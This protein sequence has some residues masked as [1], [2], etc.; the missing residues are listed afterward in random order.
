VQAT[1]NKTD[2]V[3]DCWFQLQAGEGG[4]A[5]C[6]RCRTEISRVEVECPPGLL[7][8]PGCEPPD[9]VRVLFVGVAP[10]KTGRHFYTDPADN[11]R[12]GLF[13]ILRELDRPC[14]DVP[15]FLA[16]GFFLVH[17]A[18]CAI[19]GTTKPNLRVSRCC[20]A[21]HLRREIE[22]LMPD[23]ICFLSKNIAFP[24]ST[25][26]LPRWVGT[27][28]G[29][30]RRGCHGCRRH[31]ANPRDLDYL[32]RTGSPQAACPGPREGA[33]RSPRSPNVELM[34]AEQAVPPDA[35][36]RSLRSLGAPQ[37]NGRVDMRSTV[38]RDLTLPDRESCSGCLFLAA[39]V[40]GA[41][42]LGRGGAYNSDG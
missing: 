3:R 29:T 17:T 24:V 8:P 4:V 28:T 18:K 36:P 30:V 19:R 5:G 13:D 26:L 20:G 31:E 21:T 10:P 15:D 6:T 40:K 32:A 27:Q 23:G 9:A 1:S 14:R 42:T 2:T 16:R 25:D 22:C 37:V 35:P 7:Y 34:D 11:L 38:K 41:R 12:R 33:V 39:F